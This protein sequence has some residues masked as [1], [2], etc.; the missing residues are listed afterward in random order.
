M[1]FNQPTGFRTT[2]VWSGIATHD[3]MDR[4]TCGVASPFWAKLS[5]DKSKEPGGRCIDGCCAKDAV[6]GRVSRG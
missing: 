5:R 6:A 3:V 1:H 2:I 4:L